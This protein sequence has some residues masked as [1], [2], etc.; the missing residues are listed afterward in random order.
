LHEG[1][2]DELHQA[3]CTMPHC[4]G[5]MVIEI[6]VDMATFFHIV[7]NEIINYSVMFTIKLNVFN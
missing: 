6:F 3:M 1:A 5:S 4:P 7:D 2:T